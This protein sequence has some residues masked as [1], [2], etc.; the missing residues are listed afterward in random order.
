M[1]EGIA[2]QS[3]PPGADYAAARASVTTHYRAGVPILAGTDA[4]AAP[5]VP[6]VISHG[7]SLHH[8]LELLVDAGLTKLDALRAATS[9]PA[10]YFGLADRGVIEPGRRADLV[11]IDGDPL[12]DIKATRLIRLLW[13]GG[14]ERMPS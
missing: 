3:A 7:D 6:A 4:N 10:R 8:E 5:G 11:L 1:M 12:Q 9:L 14:V 2:L 13:C